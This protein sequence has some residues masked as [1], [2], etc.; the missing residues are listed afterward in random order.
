MKSKNLLI[1]F[2]TIMF[3]VGVFIISS[4][5]SFGQAL[6]LNWTSLGPDN[7]AG[8][9]RALLLWNKDA[10]N[11]TLFAG[12][13]SG[14][15]WKSTTSG[16]TWNQINTDNV[17]LNVSCIAQAPNGDIYVGTGE[18]F[19][20][21]RFNIYS[22][23]IGQGIYKSTDGISFTKLASTNPGT[24]ND[25]NA[26]WAFINKIAVG[27]NNNVYAATNKGLKVS[28][29]GGQTWALAKSAG[30][31][32][33]DV[34]T[35]VTISSDGTVAASVGNKVYF[36]SNGAADNF[37][38]V[39]GGTGNDA[40][41]HN[42]LSRIVLAFSGDASTVYAMLISDGSNSTYPRGSLFGI[43]V[44]KNK[45]QSWRLIA[46]GGSSQFGVFGVGTTQ[47][48]DYSASMVVSSKNPDLL[49]IGGMDIWEGLK[50]QEEGFYQWQRKTVGQVFL[51]HNIILDPSELK[52]YVSSDQGIYQ[53][54][55]DFSVISGLN[56]NYRT[57]M[58]YTVGYDDKGNVIGGTQ[59][60][61]I[62][63]IDGNG[64]SHEAAQTIYG[65]F[66]GGSVEMS[67][68]SPKAMF[69]SSA[70]GNL[71]RSADL[72]VSI[73]NNFVPDNIANANSGVL[74]TPFRMWENF[75]NSNSRDSVSYIAKENLNAGVTVQVKSRTGGFLFN[76]TLENNLTKGDS[77]IVQ[78]IISSRFFIGVTNAV[79]MSKQVLDFAYEPKWFKIANIEGV[80]TSLSYSEDA[81]YLFV[82]CANGNVYR[83]ANI[84]LANDSLKADIGS[85]ACII[86]T[87]LIQQF[88]GR[89]VTSVAVD[90]KNPARVLVTLSNYGND[91]FVY[92]TSNAL[93]QNPEFISVQGNLPKMPVYSSL[94]EMNTS[95]VLI[96]TDFGIYTTKS[97]GANTVWTAENNGMG[98][99]PIISIRQQ[100]VSRPY[101]DGFTEVANRGAIY[102]ASLGNGIFEN[103]MYVGYERPDDK[104]KRNEVLLSVYPNPVTNQINFNLNNERQENVI[105][106]IYDLKGNM[107]MAKSFGNV[108]K[109]LTKI[110]IDAENLMPG[111]YLMQVFSGMDVQRAKFVVIK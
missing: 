69:Y 35:E 82:G 55:D 110:S 7:Y 38:L 73:A 5:V 11:K 26:E 36:S 57:S 99:L 50:V 9:T 105:V 68:I 39:S 53:A 56:R 28:T 98:A 83:I 30:V 103:K 92:F 85:T 31:N 79:Y 100:T 22:G 13:A 8:R 97:L 43:Y 95:N 37:A 25:P 15:L 74:L 19:A 72:G 62:L 70:G 60:N 27:N 111:S 4:S 33:S 78:D 67:M 102:L 23:F 51:I 58:F 91:N 84:A 47:Y 41:P 66:Q 108:Q 96:G 88:P 49:Y 29:D 86:S 76:Y 94:F 89:N 34:S 32:L 12:G 3:T 107:V 48:G 54:T 21:E 17:I 10:Q 65:A 93:D 64:N 101:I 77:V 63:Y 90:Q 40:L 16:L 42:A 104:N 71:L 20:S 52:A 109:G 59:G 75:N 80:P 81:N 24:F 1:G 46:P 87:S 6:G 106:K 2:L 14:G 44:S 45:G 18:T 61:G